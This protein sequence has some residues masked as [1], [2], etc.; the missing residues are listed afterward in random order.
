MLESIN[1]VTLPESCFSVVPRNYEA[2][3]KDIIIRKFVATRFGCGID[4]TTVHEYD[5]KSIVNDKSS[6]MYVTLGVRKYLQVDADL[7]SG[8]VQGLN[9]EYVAFNFSECDKYYFAKV[10]RIMNL[11][12]DYDLSYQRAKSCLQTALDFDLITEEDYVEMTYKAESIHNGEYW[13][14]FINVNSSLKATG[15]FISIGQKP[16]ALSEMLNYSNNRTL[17]SDEA[18]KIQKLLANKDTEKVALTLLNTVNPNKSFVELLCLINHMHGDIRR[19]NPNV[20]ILPLLTGAYDVSI[21][22]RK[23]DEIVKAYT[24][25]FGYTSNEI[26]EKIADNYYH[27]RLEKSSVFDFKL[28]IK[29]W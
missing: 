27:P 4:N 13:N 6:T 16:I 1:V 17:S 22:T 3:R 23:S 7:K 14:S 21:Y 26:L 5:A 9:C 19:S 20:P 2:D 25:N 24:T 28:K 8:K 29:K 18:A 11:N 12:R 15:Q 10:S